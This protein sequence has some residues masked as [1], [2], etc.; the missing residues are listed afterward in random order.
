MSGWYRIGVVLSVL[1]F[2]GFGLV[3]RVYF[4]N[5]AGERLGREFSFCSMTWEAE[6]DR[7]LHEFGDE[8]YQDRPAFDKHTAE[9]LQNENECRDRASASFY[10]EWVSNWTIAL[11]A[12]ISVA[13]WWL[14]GLIGVSV[15]RWVAAGFRRANP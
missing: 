5:S 9:L 8:Y 15:G 7:Y 10:N 3:L 2:I 1:W 12:A 13:L 6:K 11:I 14:V 4:T